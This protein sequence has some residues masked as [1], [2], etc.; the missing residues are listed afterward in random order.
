MNS[1]DMTTKARNT[2]VCVLYFVRI[3]LC[4]DFEFKYEHILTASCMYTDC[5]QSV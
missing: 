5:I 3:C 4:L 2:T 1:E